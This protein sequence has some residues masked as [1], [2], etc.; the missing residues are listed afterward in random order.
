MFPS[1]ALQDVVVCVAVLPRCGQ[2]VLAHSTESKVLG[3]ALGEIGGL[4]VCNKS[5]VLLGPKGYPGRLEG[6]KA[7]RS[8]C[9][10]LCKPGMD[11][12]RN[13]ST[14]L[15]NHNRGLCDYPITSPVFQAAP[16]YGARQ[17]PIIPYLSHATHHTPAGVQMHALTM[18]RPII[19]FHTIAY[20]TLSLGPA[21]C[22]TRQYLQYI[23]N[24]SL[25]RSIGISYSSQVDGILIKPPEL[26]PLFPQV[27]SPNSRTS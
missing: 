4:R 1:I 20:A 11:A 21:V 13:T 17:D 24:K 18:S 26:T 15:Y 2:V 19:K 8:F 14:L 16:L 25:I 10:S 23:T 3:T 22:C 6:S 5:L 12:T 27:S 9:L 7:R